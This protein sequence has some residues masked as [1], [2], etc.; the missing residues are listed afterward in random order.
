LDFEA[1]GIFLLNSLNPSIG[2]PGDNCI[3]FV[4]HLPSRT[5]E[6]LHRS[7]D[8]LMKGYGE[9]FSRIFGSQLDPVWTHITR[10]PMYSPTFGP[11][12][13]NPPVRSS[14]WKNVYFAGNYRTFPSIASTGTALW[15]GLE[16]GQAILQDRDQDTDILAA[17]K[18]FR[19]HR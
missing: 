9:D 11:S 5:A 14:T 7:D 3:N 19:L 18:R 4:T 2:A 8:E 15:S 16:A 13:Q 1:C 17:V 10:L 6:F 12:Y